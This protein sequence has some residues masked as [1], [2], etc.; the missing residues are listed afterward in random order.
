MVWDYVEGNPFSPS[1]GNLLD[2]VGWIVKV[3]HT[4]LSAKSIGTATQLDAR[5]Q[6][7][8]KSKV[9]STDPP[10][11][12]N[13]GYADLSRTSSMSGCGTH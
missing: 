9:I 3:I 2:A 11:F 8:S 10:Y 12:D 6:N 13:V 1:S 7:L 5:Q 4:S